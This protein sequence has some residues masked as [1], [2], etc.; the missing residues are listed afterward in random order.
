MRDV[1]VQY[2]LD[3]ST[4]K[5]VDSRIYDFFEDLTSACIVE[6]DLFATEGWKVGANFVDVE[7]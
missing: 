4:D 7:V 5:F 6:V 1:L 3:W 2:C